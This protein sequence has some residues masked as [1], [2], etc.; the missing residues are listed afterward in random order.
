MNIALR[1]PPWDETSEKSSLGFSLVLLSS[2]ATA[3]VYIIAKVVIVEEQ[4]LFRGGLAVLIA[5]LIQLFWL[6]W[7]ERLSWLEG[8]SRKGWICTAIFTI[9]S[10]VSLGLFYLAIATIDAA[11]AGFVSRTSIV[12]QVLLGMALLAERFNPA[13]MIG[14]LLVIAGAV[15]IK[16]AVSLEMSAGFWLMLASAA[17]FGVVEV[18]A[19]VAVRYIMPRYLNSIRNT[20]AG[21]VL[22][23]LA[24]IE[25]GADWDMGD[26]WWG[27]VGLA[28]TGPLAARIIFLNAL[29]HIEVSK[30]ALVSQ[31]QPIFVVLLAI[32]LLNQYPS[33]K[34]LLGGALIVA[35]GAGVYIFRSRKNEAP[36]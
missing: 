10:M 31:A 17:V 25:G 27:I 19:K 30:A 22:V 14:G 5:G 15:I 36:H 12:V 33:G 13:E 16:G 26:L 3:T 23:T 24:L 18:S 6:L 1:R 32:L 29:K 7:R 21:G 8:I 11:S 34:T 28:V 2:G 9:T 4:A 20:V 35:G